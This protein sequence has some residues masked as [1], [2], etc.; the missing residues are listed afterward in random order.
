MIMKKFF[1]LLIA[2]SIFSCNNSGEHAEKADTLSHIPSK[3]DNPPALQDD[4]SGCY[5]SVSGRD[6][7]VASLKQTNNQVS[8]KLSF[9]N[10]EK[11]ASS[12]K[13]SGTREGDVVKL[14]YSFQSEGMNS[15][16]DVW[17]QVTDGRLVRGIGEI[18]TRGDTAYFADPSSIAYTGSVFEKTSCD[19]LA[20][21]YK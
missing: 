4:I 5:I 16:M 12:G 15:V 11:D 20:E 7:F 3:K 19:D 6:T 1:Y 21:K 10:F 14:I 9:D 13:V 8:G 18:K 17:F 2:I